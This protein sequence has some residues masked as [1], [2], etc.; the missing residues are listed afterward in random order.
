[1]VITDSGLDGAVLRKA[2][3]HFPSGIVAVC[4][5]IDGERVGMA[6]S[7][8][9]PVSLDPPLVAV[10]VQNTSATWPRLARSPRI[11]ISVLSEEHDSAVRS[12]AAKHGDRFDKLTTATHD[13]GA[14]F[15][16]GAG[17]W[18]ATSVHR[19]I[20]TGDHTTV[21]LRIEGLRTAPDVAPIIFHR[22][23]LRRLG[24]EPA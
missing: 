13:G 11:G 10:C 22:S 8:F 9:V 21:V 20:P 2:F 3:G 1:M 6:V 24:R 12:L 5:E 16:D 4:A 7:S 14:L 17:L 23:A 19:Q 15:L 18:L